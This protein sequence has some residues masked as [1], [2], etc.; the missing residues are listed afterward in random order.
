[1]TAQ[2]K[3]DR[4][5]ETR[6]VAGQTITEKRAT[7]S[8]THQDYWYSR[9]KKRSYKGRDGVL[10]EVPS[11]QVRIQHLGKEGWFNL[12]TNNRAAAAVKAR[13]IYIFLRANGWGA[14]EE[15]F[16]P[17]PEPKIKSPT[18]GQFLEEVRRTG[19]FQPKTLA[20]YERKLRKIVADIVEL[21]S[22]PRKHDQRGGGGKEWRSC[23][24]KTRLD[25]ITPERVESWKKRFVAERAKSAVET[26]HAKNSV[27][28]FLRNAKSLFSPL[29]LQKLT[30]IAGPVVSPFTDVKLE[31]SG[32]MRYRS[33][34]EPRILFESARR[35]LTGHRFPEFLIF[36]L[37]LGAGLRRNEIDKMEW[38][39]IDW[40]SKRIHVQTTQHFVPKTE[41][42]ENA[43]D[44]DDELLAMLKEQMPHARSEFVVP[45]G[46]VKMS[47]RY[48]HYRCQAHFRSL[49]QWLRGKGISAPNPLHSLRKEF[50]SLICDEH[51]MYVASRALRHGST[52]TTQKHYLDKKRH[53]PLKLAA[54]LESPLLKAL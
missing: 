8:K 20:L 39:W 4:I 37:A 52:Q 49:T 7:L 23:V 50:G 16:K 21:S 2:N 1:M 48:D 11:W 51:G 36:V 6:T 40:D 35:E 29:V 25:E 12:D 5:T 24:D 31:R 33:E 27:N 53:A 38:S 32:S 44:V 15:K 10:A 26:R 3:T 19:G 43:V 18:L 17:K 14:T 13:D 30:G 28:S 22:D 41:E 46:A 42:S 34:I 47:E 9:L 45:G 54:F